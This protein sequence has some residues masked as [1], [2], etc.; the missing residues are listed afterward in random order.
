MP[1]DPECSNGFFV[2]ATLFADVKE[3]MRIAREEMFGAIGEAPLF[4]AVSFILTDKLP[5]TVMPFDTDEDA[6]RI[7]NSSEYGL[8]AAIY[9]RDMIRSNRVSRSLDVG[10]VFVNNYNRAILGT[11]FGGVKHSGYGREHCIETLYEWCKPKAVHSPSGIGE[12]PKWRGIT[13]VFGPSGS[14]V[15]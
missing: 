9:T 4:V 15:E 2:P 10:M 14:K 7:A 5:V 13:D 11:P 8:T 6:I 1:L 12:V 3:D